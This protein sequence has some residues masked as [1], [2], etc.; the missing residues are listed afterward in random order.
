MSP[1]WALQRRWILETTPF[2]AERITREITVPGS[3]QLQGF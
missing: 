2:K 3:F 1:K